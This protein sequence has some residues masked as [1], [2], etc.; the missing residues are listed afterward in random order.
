MG[1]LGSGNL[2]WNPNAGKGRRERVEDTPYIDAGAVMR[3]ATVEVPPTERVLSL[4]WTNPYTGRTE[5][6][7]LAV[8]PQAC[9]FS[10]WRWWFFCPVC[11]K[12][13]ARLYI[14]RDA[15]RPACRECHGLAYRSSQQAHRDDRDARMVAKLTGCGLDL[16]RAVV[17]T[18]PPER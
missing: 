1:G 16:A 2:F 4:S 5:T 10:G 9:R 17:R 14:P 15:L 13:R 18:Y 11:G 8:A 6:A 7:D 3:G 12:R